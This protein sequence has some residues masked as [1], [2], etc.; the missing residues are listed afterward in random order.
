LLR[1]LRSLPS[2]E[3]E[4][5]VV[6]PSEP[7]LRAEFEKAG[8]TIHVVPMRRI[9]RSYGAREWIAYAW[10]WPRSV[11]EIR[12]LIRQLNI[13]VV[14]SNSLHS[15]YGWAAARRTRRPHLWHAREIVIQSPAA[16]S[17][18]RLLTR[19]FAT[20]V[21]CMSRAIA[22]QLNAR[23][24]VV[25][26]ESVDADEFHPGLA[27]S[28]R[29][30]VGIADDVPLVGAAG[31]IDSW[32]GLD[33]LLDAFELANA[34]QRPEARFELVIAGA[35]VA[36]KERL[37]VQLERRARALRGVHWLGPR[38]DLPAVLADLDLFVLPSTA[39]EPYGLVVVEALACGVPCV[40]SNAG[41]VVEIAVAAPAG[42]AGVVPP[43][44]PHALAAALRTRLDPNAARSAAQRAARPSLAPRVPAGA[45]ASLVREISRAGR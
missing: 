5:H 7:P 42:A 18:E 29:S 12:W 40:V 32:K 10:L 39:P 36:G 23:K 24:V 43:G 30:G 17:V 38:D 2:D 35:T 16:L 26:Y 9:S 14:H 37:A 27:G 8:A 31:R 4:C 3:F 33:V 20:M 34:G 19:R 1:L 6:V 41:G 21:I 15:W 13:D 44:N 28:F 22:E 11:R 25:L 45:F